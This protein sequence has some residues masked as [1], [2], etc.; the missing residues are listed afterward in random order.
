M[1]DCNCQRGD[2]VN[3]VTEFYYTNVKYFKERLLHQRGRM[4]HKKYK[5]NVYSWNNTVH[6]VMWSVVVCNVNVLPRT[7]NLQDPDI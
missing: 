4:V 1:M 3:K 6:T 7:W 5:I 2:M